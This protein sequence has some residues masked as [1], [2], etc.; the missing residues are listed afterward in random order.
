MIMFGN[1]VKHMY[2]QVGEGGGEGG[3]GSRASDQ[4]PPGFPSVKMII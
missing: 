4:V 1:Y 2:I 3:G